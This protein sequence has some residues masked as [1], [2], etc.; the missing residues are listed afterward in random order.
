MV[1]KTVT[2]VGYATAK[3][4]F[5]EQTRAAS[6]ALV[7]A[8]RKDEGCITSSVLVDVK[9]PH[10]FLL[11]EVWKSVDHWTKHLQQPHLSAFASIFHECA[12]DFDVQKF[13]VVDE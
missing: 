4:G 13:F 1:T 6:L 3:E 2:V 12:T 5:I 11:H 9:D 10:K 7:R 8:N